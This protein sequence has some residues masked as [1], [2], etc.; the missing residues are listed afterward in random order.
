M[1]ASSCSP[2]RFM[3][4]VF[5]SS[6]SIL[7]VYAV[8]GR[9]PVRGSQVRGSHVGLQGSGS[10]RPG[11]PGFPKF[12]YFIAAFPLGATVRPTHHRARS[13]RAGCEWLGTIWMRA[14][15]GVAANVFNCLS[16]GGTGL[17]GGHSRAVLDRWWQVSR[18][19]CI[20][21]FSLIGSGMS[22]FLRCSS[23]APWVLRGVVLR[24]GGPGVWWLF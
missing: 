15:G 6:V 8:L 11:I 19:V 21:P 18:V 9:R 13:H 22:F 5:S 12:A 3:A 7:L 17:E 16:V 20:F 10:F 4:G 1:H 24:A 2:L 14:V 23:P